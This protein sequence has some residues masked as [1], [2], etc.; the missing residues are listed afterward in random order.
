MTHA[1][2]NKYQPFR[3]MT[4]RDMV[5]T[6]TVTPSRPGATFGV[7]SLP[8]RSVSSALDFVWSSTD[9]PTIPSLPRRSPAE[10][11]IAQALVGI[12]GVSVGQ[13]G[14]ISVDVATLDVDQFI[15]TDIMSDAYGAFA[16]FLDTFHERSR[17][18]SHVKWQFVGPVTLGMALVRIGLD[19]SVS[20]RLALQAVSAHVGALQHEVAQACGDI[21]Q[22]IILDEPSLADALEP[23]FYLNPDGVIDLI[24][25]A[26]ATI[27]SPNISGVHSCGRTD[28]GTMLATGA[29]VLSVPVSSS[30]PDDLAEMLVA[31]SRISDHLQHGGRIAWG[32][33]RTD[34][35]I[36]VTS[37]RSWKLLMEAMCAL[38]RAGVDP[39]LLRRQCFITPACGLAAHTDQVA[40]RV[41]GHVHDVATRVAEQATASRLTLGS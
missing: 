13:Y 32:A 3:Q 39:L 4:R 15:T 20:F 11:M 27:Q 18:T 30:A 23:G 31:A 41:F 34:G 25:G 22:I 37:E 6:E 35:P 28:W 2:T 8:H 33:V 29:Q 36:A 10:G 16:A 1:A 19:P 5:S 38:V 7:G 26:L 21:T 17:G 12:E 9:I 40:G 14:G 24:S